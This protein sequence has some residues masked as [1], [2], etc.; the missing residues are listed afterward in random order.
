MKKKFKISFISR[1]LPQMLLPANNCSNDSRR[2][3]IHRNAPSFL[4]HFLTSNCL[5]EMEK[6][7]SGEMEL[8]RTKIS[9]FETAI[10]RLTH[11][12]HRGFVLSWRC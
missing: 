11:L 5:L 6:F 10:K 8:E 7:I 4:V 12:H 1:A 2:R 3:N 9:H